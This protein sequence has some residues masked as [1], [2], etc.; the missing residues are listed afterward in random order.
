MGDH[1]VSEHEA[2]ADVTTFAGAAQRIWQR[3]TAGEQTWARALGAFVAIPAIAL[4]WC[5]V[6]VRHVVRA[7]VVWPAQR[8]GRRRQ[9]VEDL[10]DRSVKH[11]DIV[12]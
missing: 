5:G 6:A 8:L 7:V 10:G 3:A 12:T 2:A 4:A 9:A 1:A 11:A